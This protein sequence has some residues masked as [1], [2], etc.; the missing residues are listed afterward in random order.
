MRRR[1]ERVNEQTNRQTSKWWLNEIVQWRI[2]SEY[3]EKNN[4]DF[5]T[6]TTERKDKKTVQFNLYYRQMRIGSRMDLEQQ[7]P[8]VG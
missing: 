4:D 2:K 5:L 1:A 7:V 3:I 8:V 6:S